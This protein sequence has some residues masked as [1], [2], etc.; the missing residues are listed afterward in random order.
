MQLL[1]RS[2]LR[3]LFLNL[4]IISLFLGFSINFVLIIADIENKHSLTSV[5]F[6]YKEMNKKKKDALNISTYNRQKADIE[7]AIS[8]I[9]VKK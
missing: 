7:Y 4:F 8:K 1:I 5:E 6:L 9:P 2:K 3:V